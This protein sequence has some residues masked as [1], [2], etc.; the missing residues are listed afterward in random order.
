MNLVPRKQRGQ[1]LSSLDSFF[2]DDFFRFPSL[3]TE[4][5]GM[6]VSNV[7]ISETEKEFQVAADLP[8]F[9]KEDIKVRVEDGVLSIS[10]TQSMEKE[11]KDDDKKYYCKQCSSG[12]FCRQVALPV[13]ADEK[14]AV[15]KMKDGKLTVT[16]PKLQ[17][18]SKEKGRTLEIQ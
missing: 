2:D 16:I 10:G 14:N 8:G 12:S 17:N 11:D 18:E 7:D 15:C 4:R 13:S 5:S 9:K 1:F 6:F 3:F